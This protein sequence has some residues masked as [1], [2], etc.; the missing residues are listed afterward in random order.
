V[1]SHCH[2]T[3]L[4]DGLE[5]KLR[6]VRATAR[7]HTGRGRQA[8]RYVGR[9][10]LAALV[11][12]LAP[13]VS[14]ASTARPI[15][16]HDG[17]D[18][19][20]AAAL[21]PSA[22][23]AGEVGEVTSEARAFRVGPLVVTGP[24]TRPSPGGARLTAGYLRIANTGSEPDRLIGGSARIAGKLEIHASD[25]SGGIARMRALHDGIEIPAGATIEL[26]P[27]G[28]HLMFASLEHAV[29]QGEVFEATLVFEKAGPLVVEFD[30]RNHA[31]VDDPDTEP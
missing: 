23:V 21:P 22:I 8:W 2:G 30:V 25:S 29:G 19:G 26:E 4:T 14:E 15:A 6:A 1:P 24:W 18:H 31:K 12:F 16:L 5:T 20:S 13:C 10:G 9:V 3:A 27:G 28:K 17:R 11:P 7:R